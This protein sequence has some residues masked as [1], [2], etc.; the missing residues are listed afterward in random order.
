MVSASQIA[1]FFKMLY[2]K[3][4]V[5]NEVYFWHADNLEISLQIDSITLAV[6]S[7]ACPKYSRQQLY[8]IFEGRN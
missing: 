3:K 8:N 2:L 6:R 7:Q 1:V 5:D 4:K